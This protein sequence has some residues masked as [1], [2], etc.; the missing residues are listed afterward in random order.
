M[1][2]TIRAR[3]AKSVVKDLLDERRV[4]PGSYKIDS[5]KLNLLVGARVVEVPLPRGLTFYG[6]QDL[7]RKVEACIREMESARAHRQQIDLE[8][9]IA[10]AP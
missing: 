3:E 1:H 2:G 7:L 9:V 4:S 5:R 10:A 6:M 8:E